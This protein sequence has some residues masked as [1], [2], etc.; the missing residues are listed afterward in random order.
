MQPVPGLK[1]QVARIN[2]T[3][4]K[5]IPVFR[6][7]SLYFMGVPPGWYTANVDSTQLRILGLQSDPGIMAFVIRITKEGDYVGN[8]DF[9]LR[10]EEGKKH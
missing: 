2:G 9:I 6:D 7:G 3:F 8:L 4:R 1:V 5:T 10:E